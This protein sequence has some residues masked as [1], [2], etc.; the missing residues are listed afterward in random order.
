MNTL[1]VEDIEKIL[2]IIADTAIE[3][4]KYF[5]ELDAATGDGDFGST[6][7][8]GFKII[9][10]NLKDINQ[11]D[12]G[13]LLKSFGIVM[14]E[15]CGGVTGSLWGSAFRNAGKY[16]KGMSVIGLVD[17][18]ELLKKFYEGMQKVGG[19]VIGDKTLLD[20]LIP[21]VDSFE[22]EIGKGTE[23][24]IL[25]IRKMGESAS[26]GAEKTKKMIAKKGRAAYLG[27]RSIGHPD[28][29]AV[30]ISIMFENVNKKLL[31]SESKK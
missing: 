15:S 25:L 6:L 31:Q 30:A 24:F 26:A 21:A 11:K 22:K 1:E 29:G 17:A 7:A 20:A 4:E 9:K 10:K 23:D 8:K 19:A 14:M 16:A 3:N 18:M 28:A 27:E 12:I 5:C 13:E 2:M